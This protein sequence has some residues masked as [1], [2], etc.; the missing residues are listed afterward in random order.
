MSRH[1]KWSKIKGQKAIDDKK[2]GAAFTRVVKNITVAAK[3]KGANPATNFKLRLAM[4]QAKA[5]NMPKENVERAIERASGGAGGSNF[6]PLVFEGFTPGGAAIMIE[7]LSDNSTRTA[8]EIKLIFS[9]H[10]GALGAVKWMF[11]YFGVLAVAGES[12]KD[13]DNFELQIIETGAIDIKED[14]G[15]IIIYTNPHDLEKIK[16]TVEVL[17][18]KVEYAGLN[19]VAKEKIVLPDKTKET[20]FE[21]FL[22]L[23]DESEEV[24]E[25]YT[26]VI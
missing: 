6:S 12:V 8:N 7:S 1:N 19:W 15:N 18:A 5:V 2:K 16:N 3:E 25:Y 26:N 17:G 14:E 10:G 11:D 4:D 23:L 20:L 9:K 21:Q 13:S 24:G 22:E